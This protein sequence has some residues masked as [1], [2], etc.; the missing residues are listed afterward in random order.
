MGSKNLLPVPEQCRSSLPRGS[1][2]SWYRLV[3]KLAACTAGIPSRA[4]QGETCSNLR[5]Q[6]LTSM[7]GCMAQ[8]GGPCLCIGKIADTEARRPIGL[9]LWRKGKNIP[10]SHRASCNCLAAIG[11]SG[12]PIWLSLHLQWPGSSRL[13]CT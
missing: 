1:D 5:Y 9:H 6:I 4:G 8:H 10:F 3:P 7:S 2:G 12:K 11:C 13:H